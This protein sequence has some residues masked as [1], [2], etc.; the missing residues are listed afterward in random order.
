MSYDLKWTVFEPGVN[1]FTLSLL[2][3]AARSLCRFHY[4]H[5]AHS[6]VNSLVKSSDS[7]WGDGHWKRQLSTYFSAHTISK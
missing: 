3:S 6:N 4:F 7:L 5:D 1:I 2:A